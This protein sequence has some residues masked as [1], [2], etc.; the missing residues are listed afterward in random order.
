MSLKPTASLKVSIICPLY[1]KLRYLKET[2][3]SVRAQTYQNWEM[4]LVDDGS[5]DGSFELAKAVAERENRIR[6]FQREDF[7]K[8]KGA[9]VC[10]NIGIQLSTGSFI[11]F[12]DADDLLTE[13]CLENRIRFARK[14]PN[15]SFYIF[16]S[17]SFVRQPENDPLKKRLIRL[18]NKIRLRFVLDKR[19]YFLN[20]FCA[21]N[22]LWQTSYVLWKPSCLKALN[23]FSESF[24]RLQDPELHIR[25]LADKGLEF[26]SFL[27]KN[28]PDALIRID[29]DRRDIPAFQH[30]KNHLEGV[31]RFLDFFSGYLK[32]N[33]LEKYLP[34]LEGYILSV[35]QMNLYYRSNFKD[36]ITLIQPLVT[37]FYQKEIVQQVLS[38]R[39]KRLIGLARDMSKN[40]YLSKFKL[41][42]LLLLIYKQVL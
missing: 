1:N 23:G 27:Y 8:P 13:N 22:L 39:G 31:V 10:R 12:L 6:I 16:N 5:T 34:R 38:K 20:C 29:E 17:R 2:L 24:Q 41:P 4:V 36:E 19:K 11:L 3:D 7:R 42:N 40:K 14:Y 28:K 33:Q 35:E 32:K 30:F 15:K 21:Y 9:S 26:H 18:K 37:S 25:A